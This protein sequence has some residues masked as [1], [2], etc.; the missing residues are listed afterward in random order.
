MQNMQPLLEKGKKYLQRLKDKIIVVKLGG[1]VIKDLASID[2]ISEDVAVLKKMG[3]K[4][5]V[6]HGGG[7]QVDE[8]SKKLGHIPKKVNGSRITDAAALEIAKMVFGGK[9]NIELLVS[10]RKFGVKVVG[11]SGVDGN[12]IKARKRKAKVITINGKKSSEKIDFGYVGDVLNV[13]TAILEVLMKSG[14]TPV[15]A[16][17]GSD[18]EGNL[19]NIN[20]DTVAEVIAIGMKAEKLF[21]LSNVN[22]VL[23]NQ[24]DE[25]SLIPLIDVDEAKQMIKENLITEGMVPKLRS[26]IKSVLGGVKRT[27]IING[28]KKHSLLTEISTVKGTGTMVLSKNEKKLYLKEIQNERRKIA[29]QPD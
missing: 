21:N 29:L 2:M 26:C 22:G 28:T 5:I 14:Y 19:F 23:K 12:L 3:I 17:L 18:D 4:I 10:L 11:L 13:D 9:I 20:A 24:S 8:L 15:I 7:P 6:V 16:S 25:S 1:Y 27:H